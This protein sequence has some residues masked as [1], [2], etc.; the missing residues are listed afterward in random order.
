GGKAF[1]IGRETKCHL[2]VDTRVEGVQRG[3]RDVF[4]ITVVLQAF[5]GVGVADDEPRKFPIVAKN[6]TEQPAIPGGGN[7]VQIKIRAHS[8]ADARLDRGVKRFEVNILQKSFGNVR[9]VVI[10]TA[11][12]GAVASEMFH[13][14]EDVIGRADVV[15]LKSADL[16]G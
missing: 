5:D 4:R 15:T 2:H 7:V 3:F 12:G 13:A 16:R 1:R 11:D 9:F 14:G 8:R 6:V 10:A